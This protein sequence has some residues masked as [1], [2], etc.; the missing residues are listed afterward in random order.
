MKLK[1][2]LVVVF[3]GGSVIALCFL[4]CNDGRSDDLLIV[5]DGNPVV[6]EEGREEDGRITKLDEAVLVED[7][8]VDYVLEETGKMNSSASSNWWVNSGAFLYSKDGVGK[9]LAGK[10]AK[11]VKWQERYQETREATVKETDGGYYPQNI[12]RL[13]TKEKWKDFEQEIYYNIRK[14]NLSKDKHRSASNA[15]LLFNRY[16]DG[17]N[18]YYTGL[19]VDG[20]VIVKKKYQKEYYTMGQ[21]KVLKGKYD[22]KDNPN[23]IPENKWV[24]VR[25][26]VETLA[27]DKVRIKVFVNFKKGADDW[28][29]VL[30]VIDDG[31]K[32]GGSAIL[33]SGY[34]GIRTDF[35]DVEFDDYRIGE[36]AGG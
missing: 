24:G 35:M 19:R 13:V 28:W 34:A 36:T 29:E 9:T 25:S 31:E 4:V 17:D 12:F 20:T 32:Y 5:D 22:R 3:I 14:Y 16:Q 15:L 10:L 26:Q 11:G 8:S 7:F 18:L 6:R 33:E 23:L 21:E 1:F 2:I 30:S 27:G